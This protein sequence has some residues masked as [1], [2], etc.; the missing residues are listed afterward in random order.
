MG[1]HERILLQSQL[2]LLDSDN[3]QSKHAIYIVL[4]SNNL[5]IG[6]PTLG[7]S[8]HQQKHPFHLVNHFYLIF[9]NLTTEM[10]K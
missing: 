1:E 3:M 4:L 6:H 8:T 5:L 2:I 7:G 9:F 10:L